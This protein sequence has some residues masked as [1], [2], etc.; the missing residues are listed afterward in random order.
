M[1][2][3]MT[4]TTL[5][6]VVNFKRS[7]IVVDTGLICVAVLRISPA[8]LVLQQYVHSLVVIIAC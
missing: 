4:D 7:F 1:N 8:A 3:C 6:H 2:V 5:S